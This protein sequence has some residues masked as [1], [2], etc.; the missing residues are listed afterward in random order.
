MGDELQ[1]LGNYRW[2]RK[3]YRRLT[4]EE[5]MS[6]RKKYAAGVSVAKL[7]L[8]YGVNWSTV[9]RRCSDVRVKKARAIISFGGVSVTGALV[10]PVKGSPLRG[11][12]ALALDRPTRRFGD[13]YQC[14]GVGWL[15]E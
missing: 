4:D 14:D 8:A 6:M 3:G 7:A 9:W 5:I 15:F 10:R 13:G 12:A 11:R 2:A 1:L